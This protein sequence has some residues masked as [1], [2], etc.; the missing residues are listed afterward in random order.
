VCSYELASF[1]SANLKKDGVRIANL[2]SA[3]FA[4]GP[5]SNKLLIPQ[6]C[7]F[8]FCGPN[9]FCDLRTFIVSGRLSSLNG[10]A[11]TDYEEIR[12]TSAVDASEILYDKNYTSICSTFVFLGFRGPKRTPLPYTAG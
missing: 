1:K 9:L 4:E 3:T 10:M 2:Q 6:I 5:Q 12:E 11:E 7:G 8:A